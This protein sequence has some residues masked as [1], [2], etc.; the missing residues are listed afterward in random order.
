MGGVAG[1][2]LLTVVHR[3]FGGA[4]MLRDIGCHGAPFA[5]VDRV[6]HTCR[7]APMQGVWYV[8]GDCRGAVPL[9]FPDFGEPGDERR[10]PRNAAAPARASTAPQFLHWLACYWPFKLSLSSLLASVCFC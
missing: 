3:K 6:S 4:L 2:L 5:P 9:N 1:L 10:N 7:P 8:I